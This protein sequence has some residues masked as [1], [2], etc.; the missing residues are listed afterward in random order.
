MTKSALD[1]PTYTLSGTS[2]YN[3][4]QNGYWRGGFDGTFGQRFGVNKQFGFLL[5]GTWDRTNRGI[6][7]LE[8]SQAIATDPGHG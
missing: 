3:P 6:D 8:P 1:K 4:I 7:D 2:G 5:G